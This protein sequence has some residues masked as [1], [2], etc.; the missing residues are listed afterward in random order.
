MHPA[1]EAMFD[2]AENRYLKPDEL[3]VLT[4]YVESLPE[5]LNA[6]R[7][8]RDQELSI[9]QNVADQLEGRCPGESQQTLERCLKNALLVM[10]Y[11]AMAMLLNDSEFL[12]NRVVAW[13]EETNAVYQTQS[14]DTALYQLLNHR[15]GEI[16]NKEQLMLLRPHLTV[17]EKAVVMPPKAAAMA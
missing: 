12:T 8:L 9:M 4:T 5:R 17:A 11:A 2:E 15:L 16:L 13:L 10:R 6:Y 3:T 14:V 7:F 1:I